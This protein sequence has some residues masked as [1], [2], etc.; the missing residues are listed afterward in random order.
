MHQHPLLLERNKIT[1]N[2]ELNKPIKCNY[3]FQNYLIRI[4]TSHNSNNNNNNNNN[5][6]TVHPITGH[7]DAQMEQWNNYPLL[8]TSALD[9]VVGQRHAPAAL[10]PRKTQYP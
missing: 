8:L 1:V 4:L 10:S 5:N 2:L 6:N 9:E 3:I 7:E